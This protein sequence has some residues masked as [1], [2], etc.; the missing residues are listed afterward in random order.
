MCGRVRE[1]RAWGSSLTSCSC[2]RKFTDKIVCA[3]LN[4]DYYGIEEPEATKPDVVKFLTSRKA[5]MKNFMSSTADEEVLKQIKAKSIPAAIV[6]DRGGNLHKVVH[7]A[8]GEYGP[9][10]FT[11]E[12]DITLLVNTLL[13]SER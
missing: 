8:E 4:I 11:Y 6:Y 1:R 3:S 13:E 2:T 7:N 10:G 9:E 12:K 5:Q